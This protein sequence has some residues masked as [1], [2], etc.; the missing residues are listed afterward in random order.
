[1]VFV[2]VHGVELDAGDGSRDCLKEVRLSKTAIVRCSE[3]RVGVLFRGT[4]MNKTRYERAREERQRQRQRE[5]E[6]ESE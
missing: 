6:S 5:R 4:A 3:T 1:M 2:N